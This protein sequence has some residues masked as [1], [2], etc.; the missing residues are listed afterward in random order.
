MILQNFLFSD[1]ICKNEELFLRSGG[2]ASVSG[3]NLF[4][5]AGGIVTFDTYMN[6]FD[7]KKWQELTLVEEVR[8]EAVCKGEGL[9]K[10]FHMD[11]GKKRQAALK[12][13]D[14]STDTKVVL[15]PELKNKGGYLQAEAVAGSGLVIKS[16]SFIT[17]QNPGANVK[18][19]ALIPTYGR[20][21]A[22]NATM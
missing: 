3:E 12:R 17:P 16:M 1:E 22:V 8:L 2:C 13:I 19:A 11:N 18:A 10:I 6:I 7:L 5:S 14:F 9:L 20:T 15:H 21:E 4:I